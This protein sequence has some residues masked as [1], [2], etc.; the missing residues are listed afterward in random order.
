MT[1]RPKTL[2]LEGQV[3]QADHV[4]EVL[5]HPTPAHKVPKDLMQE[6]KSIAILSAKQ[7]GALS[8]LHFGARV[9]VARNPDKEGTWTARTAV[10][11]GGYNMGLL[12][13][14]KTEP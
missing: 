13:G 3:Y 10:S 9:I 4:L 1:E 14:G 5:L 7:A 6:C 2:S 11:G 8:S 12:A